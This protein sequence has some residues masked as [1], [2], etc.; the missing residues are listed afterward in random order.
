MAPDAKAESK[1][2]NLS[3]WWGITPNLEMRLKR[4]KKKK[5]TDLIIGEHTGRSVCLS[6]G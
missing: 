4:Q 1:S 2:N 5:D 6:V 3:F